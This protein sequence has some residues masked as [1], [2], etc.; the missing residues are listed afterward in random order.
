[1]GLKNSSFASSLQQ[2]LSDFCFSNVIVD[3]DYILIMSETIEDHFIIVEKILNTLS[4]SG[5]KVNINKCEFFRD[6]VIFLGHCSSSNG[7]KKS[8]EF[9]KRIIDYKKPQT[10][11][12]L[13]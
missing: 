7:I 10:V 2:I 8:P 5:I 1:M 3:I 4:A 9:V 6:E 12:D 11:T 13:R